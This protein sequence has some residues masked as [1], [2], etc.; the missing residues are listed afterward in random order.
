[1]YGANHFTAVYFFFC[2]PGFFSTYEWDTHYGFFEGCQMAVW[3]IIGFPGAIL[4]LILRSAK[5]S[6]KYTILSSQPSST[7]TSAPVSLPKEQEDQKND[8]RIAYYKQSK[9]MPTTI[10][11]LTQ[12]GTPNKIVI[13]LNSI[14]SY[15]T[16]GVDRFDFITHGISDFKMPDIYGRKGNTSESYYF[17]CAINELLNN[18]F[19]VTER[20]NVV[21]FR[22]NDGE[23]EV[24]LKLE[25]VELTRALQQF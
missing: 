11:F 14:E 10:K 15:Y 19:S 3:G 24:G 20:N 13:R 18:R 22:H 4:G 12:H 9:L 8:Q 25:Y 17:A 16:G 6:P 5:D 7:H 23:L 2:V 21:T 1:M